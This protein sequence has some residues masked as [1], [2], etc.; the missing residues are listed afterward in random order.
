MAIIDNQGGSGSGTDYEGNIWTASKEAIQSGKESSK[1]FD[2]SYDV[3][4]NQVSKNRE[5]LY[6][7]VNS[8]S[9]SSDSNNSSNS[10]SSEGAFVT[11]PDI[12][13]VGDNPRLLAVLVAVIGGVIWWV[14]S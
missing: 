2:V 7:A 10:D 4:Q 11:V 14:V 1:L 9:D 12:D 3:V 6:N 8:G 5:K 13:D